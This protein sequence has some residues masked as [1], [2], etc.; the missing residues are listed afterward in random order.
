MTKLSKLAL[1][2][3]LASSAFACTVERTQTVTSGY[4][5]TGWVY[6]GVT[7]ERLEEYEL[8]VTQGEGTLTASMSEAGRYWV[9][10]VEPFH[11]YTITI[12]GGPDYRPF[13]ASQ[14]FLTGQ[15]PAADG[16]QSQL[17]EAFLF[18]SPDVL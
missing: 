16:M 18:P 17:F 2:T 3:L 13:Y 15:P 10:P 12:D 7:N 8:F 4:Y 5:F 14:H 11:D 1:L 9:G 6:D